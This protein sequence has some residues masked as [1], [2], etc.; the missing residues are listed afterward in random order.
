MLCGCTWLLASSYAKW[1]AV[2]FA[3]YS[4]GVKATWVIIQKK[5]WQKRRSSLQMKFRGAFCV[6]HASFCTVVKDRNWQYCWTSIWYSEI[7]RYCDM[8]HFKANRS[9]ARFKVSYRFCPI[10]KRLENLIL[11]LW[12][13]GTCVVARSLSEWKLLW[14]RQS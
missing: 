10:V 4:D 8:H 11:L 3:D 14:K 7:L 6:G 5:K 13:V 9:R 2:L 12:Y 1:F